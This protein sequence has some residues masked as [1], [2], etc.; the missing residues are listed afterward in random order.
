MAT[1]TLAG[2]TGGTLPTFPIAFHVPPR[3]DDPQSHL[4]RTRS[5]SA[6]GRRRRIF[7]TA[8]GSRTPENRN[9]R[10]S[11]GPITANNTMGS[12]TPGAGRHSTR[13]P[14]QRYFAVT[15]RELRYQNGFDCQGLW[16]EVEDREGTSKVGNKTGSPTTASTKFV[17][18]SASAGSCRF[19]ARRNGA[20]GPARLRDGLGQP[21][22]KPGPF[23]EAVGTDRKVSDHDADRQAGDRPSPGGSSS[24]PRQPGV[25]RK[26][27]HLLDREQRDD[28]DLPQEVLRAGKVYREPRRHALV[29]SGRQRFNSQMGDRREAAS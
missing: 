8:C 11:A 13:T 15:G 29:R 6:S 25:G 18:R 16:V 7:E 14:F 28:L 12:T 27:F 19:A 26:L 4:R 9:G 2:P 22:R 5:R 20:V 1:G 3:V 10:S 17:C 21:R 24:A 23:A